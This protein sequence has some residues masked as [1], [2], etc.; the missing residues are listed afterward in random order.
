M[1]PDE[2]A[3]FFTLVVSALLIFAMLVSAY[4]RRL[5]FKMKKLEL[6]ASARAAGREPTPSRRDDRTDLLEDRV[7]VLE[8]IATDRGQD[9]AHQIEALRGR[10]ER[11]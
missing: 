3:I 4:K 6:E 5:D 1:Q 10:E 2:M 9:I 11:I 7:R 8:R